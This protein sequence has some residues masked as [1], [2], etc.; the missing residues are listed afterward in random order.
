MLHRAI[1][2]DLYHPW[3][4]ICHAISPADNESTHFCAIEVRY[5]A[6]LFLSQVEGPRTSLRTARGW[7]TNSR[8]SWPSR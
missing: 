3:S 6:F 8:S 7:A 2:Y 1:D 4:A 5:K